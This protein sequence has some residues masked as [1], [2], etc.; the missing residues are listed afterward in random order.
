MVVTV[1]PH[2]VLFR[3]GEEKQIRTG[4]LDE[5]ILDT[6][7]GLGP[8]LFYGTGI[9]AC[10][11]V[12][13]A[14][15]T[16][17]G[18]RRGKVLFINADREYQEGRAQNELR[19]E[20][21]D[22]IVSAY[23]AFEA[24]PGFATLVTREELK[25]NDDSL[26]IRRYADNAPPPEP[27]DVRA[28]LAGGIP[29]SEVDAND[30]LFS[31]HGLDPRH[32]L[33]VRG[34]GYFDF[35][36]AVSA[37]SDLKRLVGTDEG[38]LAKEQSLG[39][40]V[41]TWWRDHQ[42]GISNLAKGQ[43]LMLLRADLLASFQNAVR[44]IGLL[45]RFQVAGVIA[46]WWVDTQNDLKTIASA[47]FLGAITAWESNIVSAIED[48]DSGEKAIKKLA[49]QENPLDH[50]LVRRILPQYFE[51]ISALQVKLVELEAVVK[52]AS[53]A[54]EGA[55]PDG[56]VDPDELSEEALKAVRKELTTVRRRAKVLQKEF[57]AR[58]QEARSEL[59]EGSARALVMSILE[60]ELRATLNRYV[61]T[62][63]GLVVSAFETWWDKYKITFSAIE[64]RR[65]AA[66]DRVR[67]YMTELGYA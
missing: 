55:D 2:G 19:P 60:A 57:V 26:N 54:D 45:D 66:M 62:Q 46:S 29:T 11:L 34:D 48:R 50:K 36:A 22:K 49:S 21:I 63:R 16:K 24:I 25:E 1:M 38:V 47:G 35:V 59:T 39:A 4:F 56:D 42:V 44:P 65:E 9:P 40:A 13:R 31:A 32:L 17:P 18:E 20:H 30:S 58:L 5:D 12:L 27:Q 8:N 23:E 14:P 43:R 67:A 64:E 3:G 41:D 7:I 28:H 33:A 53:E 37:R 51:D 52:P 61:G 10:I 15:G 6:V